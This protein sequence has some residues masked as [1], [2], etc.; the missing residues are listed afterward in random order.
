MSTLG[1]PLVVLGAG[2]VFVIR[3]WRSGSCT[4]ARLRKENRFF[5]FLEALGERAPPIGLRGL[6]PMAGLVGP[7]A[8]PPSTTH[9]ASEPGRS[10]LV[11][12]FVFKAVSSGENVSSKPFRSS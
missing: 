5:S 7:E 1:R 12:M 11:G 9:E 8:V 4:L 3:P 6:L 2:A 10:A